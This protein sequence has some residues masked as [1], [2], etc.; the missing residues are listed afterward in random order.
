[1]CPSSDQAPAELDQTNA[2]TMALPDSSPGSPDIVTKNN[3]DTKTDSSIKAD[4]AQDALALLPSETETTVTASGPGGLAT[5]DEQIESTSPNDE[6]ATDKNTGSKSTTTENIEPEASG[7]FAPDGALLSSESKLDKIGGLDPAKLPQKDPENSTV[8]S[9]TPEAVVITSPA[10]EV[11]GT[12]GDDSNNGSPEA[13]ASVSTDNAADGSAE[14]DDH[15]FVDPN[16]KDNIG[17]DVIKFFY[18]SSTRK[19]PSSP[20]VT[21]PGCCNPRLHRDSDLYVKARGGDG[22]VFVFEVVSATLEKASPKFEAMI[23]GSHTRGNKE[24]WVWEL[25]DNP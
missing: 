21:T 7:H 1:M 25:D 15:K 24:E 17:N 4:E 11:S 8:R 5:I 23:Y 19:R 22:K 2:S 12:G 10:M 3:D 20:V 9:T 13:L 6:L 14:S 16:D 18:T